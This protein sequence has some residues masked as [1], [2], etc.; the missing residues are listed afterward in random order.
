MLLALLFHTSRAQPGSRTTQ[1]WVLDAPATD[2]YTIDATPHTEAMSRDFTVGADFMVHRNAD[3][4]SAEI[5]ARLRLIVARAARPLDEIE[6]DL[7]RE[8]IAKSLE[9]RALLRAVPLAN[10]DEPA[11]DFDAA[12]EAKPRM[13]QRLAP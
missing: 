8:K 13:S 3:E 5:D 4:I 11:L 7:I 2:N 12:L 6:L 10:H 1:N 9:Q